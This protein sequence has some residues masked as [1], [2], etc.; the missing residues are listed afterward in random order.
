[1]PALKTLSSLRSKRRS[2][3]STNPASNGYTQRNLTNRYSNCGSDGSAK[4]NKEPNFH[5]MILSQKL[6]KC[7]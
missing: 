6:T 5:L 7:H 3:S 1:M 4:G 2:H